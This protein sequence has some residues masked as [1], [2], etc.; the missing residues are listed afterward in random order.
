MAHDVVVG[1]RGRG[2]AESGTDQLADV[3]ELAHGVAH[4]LVRREPGGLELARARQEVGADLLLQVTGLLG[5]LDTGECLVEE[6]VKRGAHEWSFTSSKESMMRRVAI[7]AA[8][9]PL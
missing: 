3:A 7:Q 6:A 8:T 4:G 2:R 1:L 5:H 9:F